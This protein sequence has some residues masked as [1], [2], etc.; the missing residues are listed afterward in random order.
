ML[1]LAAGRRS[2]PSESGHSAPEFVGYFIEDYK[3][4]Q[5][6]IISLLIIAE[7]KRHRIDITEKDAVRRTISS[8]VTPNTS[9]RL[10]EEGMRTLNAYASGGYEYLAEQRDYKPYTVEEFLRDYIGLIDDCIEKH[11]FWPSG[12]TAHSP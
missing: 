5:R 11:P 8:L 1:G 12:S 6:L 3:M 9:T 2:D 10:T 7:L 4:V